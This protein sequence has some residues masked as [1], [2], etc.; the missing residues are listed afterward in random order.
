MLSRLK[1]ELDSDV[2]LGSNRYHTSTGTGNSVGSRTFYKY[3]DCTCTT[4]STATTAIVLYE[5]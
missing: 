4:H 3:E 1:L 5:Y 2:D